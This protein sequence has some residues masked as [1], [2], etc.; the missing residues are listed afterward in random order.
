MFHWELRAA[1]IWQL[2]GM[3]LVAVVALSV[4]VGVLAVGIWAVASAKNLS[5]GTKRVGV[6]LIAAMPISLVVGSLLN[7][8]IGALN[9]RGLYATQGSISIILLVLVFIAFWI[10]AVFAVGE[11]ADS[12][13]YG[14]AGFIIFA[15]FF[16][17]I[18]LIVVLVLPQ[19]QSPA[20][21]KCPACAEAI[22]PEAIKCKHCGEMIGSTPA[23]DEA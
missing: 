14:R 2:N 20:T 11:V 21:V 15:I 7:W 10:W 3:D 22:K 19:G 1:V 5:R 13:G 4:V 17:V 18:A 23:I 12:K 16:P 9:L 8:L 6:G